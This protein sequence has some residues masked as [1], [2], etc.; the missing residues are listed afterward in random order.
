MGFCGAGVRVWSA[1]NGLLA[2]GAGTRTDDDSRVTQ[3]EGFGTGL[4]PFTRL[5]VGHQRPAQHVTR[6]D[7]EAL[8]SMRYAP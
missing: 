3:K 7:P 8:A 1:A 5:S 6:P 2:P 4:L